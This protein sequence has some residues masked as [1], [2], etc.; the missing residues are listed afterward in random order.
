M[1]PDIDKFLIST[2]EFVLN[3]SESEGIFR[4]SG[5]VGRQRELKVAVEDGKPLDE[6][7]INDV[8]SLIKQFFREL[9]EPLIITLYHDAFIKCF[10]LPTEKDPKAALLR[11]CL[12]LPLENLGALRYT[13]HL[14]H[15][16]AQHS[17]KNRM[18]Y[19]NLA[20]VVA[21][22][23]MGGAGWKTGQKMGAAEEKILS[24][25]TSIIELLIRQWDQVG[26]VV[27]SLRQQL[28]M[29]SECFGTDDDMDVSDDNTLED[30]RDVL[31]KKRRRRSGSL[32]GIV[33]SIAQGIAKLRRSTDGKSINMSSNSTFRGE[34]SLSSDVS[35]LSQTQDISISDA[36]PYIMRKRRASGDAV[37]F[38][39]SKKQAILG[40][41]PTRSALASTPFTPSSTLKRDQNQRKIAPS[42]D[43]RLNATTPIMGTK[44]SRKKLNLFTSP[45]S[46]K[47]MKRQTSV[48]GRLE[49]PPT[50]P[51]KGKN[52][53]R[54]KSG[55]RDKHRQN[56]MSQSSENETEKKALNGC[57]SPK[58]A[59]SDP[60]LH[61]S[62]RTKE[63]VRATSSSSLQDSSESSLVVVD[64]DTDVVVDN[65]FYSEELSTE[66]V[67]TGSR[68][69]KHAESPAIRRQPKAVTNGFGKD[70]SRPRGKL[71]KS[72]ISKP[73]PLV[74]PA[75]AHAIDCSQERELRRSRR[76]EFE[77][78]Q[79]RLRGR[80]Q[81]MEKLEGRVRKA[82]SRGESPSK[83]DETS[84]LTNMAL[85]A[86][87]LDSSQASQLDTSLMEAVLPPPHGFGDQTML[88]EE[89]LSEQAHGDI[90]EGS[91][92]PDNTENGNL[93]VDSDC[94]SE[95]GFSTISGG[96]VMRR[97]ESGHYS[98]SGSSLVSSTSDHKSKRPISMPV[99]LTQQGLAD[100]SGALLDGNSRSE[101]S[102][103]KGHCVRSGERLPSEDQHVQ[104][105][106]Y[107]VLRAN[108][109]EGEYVVLRSKRETTRTA[110][111]QS[112]AESSKGMKLLQDNYHSSEED[113]SSSTH[114]KSDLNV[115]IGSHQDDLDNMPARTD[116][117][118]R[119]SFSAEDLQSQVRLTT[120]S[121]A[122]SLYVSPCR[123][124]NY[125]PHLE[126]S[127]ETHNILARAG[128]MEPSAP[129]DKSKD[130][131]VPVKSPTRSN[132]REEMKSILRSSFY[133]RHSLL[134]SSL[135][136]YKRNYSMDASLANTTSSSL[137]STSIS[138]EHDKLSISSQENLK[139]A[140]GDA[141]CLDRNINTV[142]SKPTPVVSELM[143]RVEQ[144][145]AGLEASNSQ[146]IPLMNGEFAEHNASSSQVKSHVGCPESL[147]KES[148]VPSLS[149]KT[150]D[151]ILR[152]TKGKQELGDTK[153]ANS[154]TN[155]FVTK[156]VVSCAE[157]F[158]LLKEQDQSLTLSG[159]L[160]KSLAS[161]VQIKR[162]EMLMPKHDSILDVRQA[163]IVAQSV[164]HFSKHHGKTE[165]AKSLD[166]PPQKRGNQALRIPTIFA[167]SEDEI[168]RYREM[169][170]FV[171]ERSG[172]DLE[173]GEP[174]EASD[175]DA[176][177]DSSECEGGNVTVLEVRSEDTKAK[178]GTSKLVENGDCGTA[179]KD[180]E[181][182]DS[183]V[184]KSPL[185]ECT[186]TAT[187]T[188]PASKPA[189]DLS[190]AVSSLLC[191]APIANC[192]QL[193]LCS[194][195]DDFLT[196]LASRPK[197]QT[198]P[199]TPGARTY[200]RNHLKRL[201]AGSASSRLQAFAS[202]SS[203]SSSSSLTDKSSVM[204]TDLPDD[205]GGD[206]DRQQV[207]FSTAPTGAGD[208]LHL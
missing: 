154:G 77:K 100:A 67:T 169:T 34:L 192:S 137:S 21:P 48:S 17:D 7:N 158:K 208:N 50:K 157:K 179:T 64:D 195:P 152:N 177:S 24:T 134:S 145:S 95:A 130:I 54:R 15:R 41:L 91:D 59:V 114:A 73:S 97:T 136:S 79:R 62:V 135:R 61:E 43:H 199:H 109:P 40:N 196:S 5:S 99:T 78:K 65:V 68:N 14:L 92:R 132:Y 1:T 108:D 98:V 36:T 128:Y 188:T 202:P 44:A 107:V 190:E 117:N 139:A 55:G 166:I 30:S 16:V 207:K 57:L 197:N 39:S 148:I 106:P 110:E 201:K 53:F 141:A 142:D 3:H 115:T 12:L 81:G 174:A 105:D 167:K 37:P 104:E 176:V 164:R 60:A 131:Y 23:L 156:P 206:G 66:G 204:G 155:L 175:E 129:T 147:S 172:C 2:S 163:G 25:Q 203:F 93:E 185:L 22:N 162:A 71:D 165:A 47:K 51:D 205:R 102:L 87:D 88:E 184:I 13:M 194:A 153:S 146:H 138:S 140:S 72:L 38:A 83:I 28:N 85:P 112:V 119:K 173:N 126:I 74:V 32:T 122:R 6:A 46:N 116:V 8:T 27:S 123:R 149:F 90:E 56:D 193:A 170:N 187:V 189:I 49:S 82:S 150:S 159:I 18:T 29:M 11:M 45:A 200:S 120:P 160:D 144:I 168:R 80:A 96:T 161:Q 89:L 125:K 133:D 127:R 121:R 186:N 171:R 70:S 52:I 143:Q 101:Q 181:S 26:M 182:Q 69:S 20:L 103:S 31:R 178:A 124:F 19:N 183:K 42:Q 151:E 180:T 10:Q 58:G 84:G 118:K 76:D 94:Q 4:K 111:R 113:S 63:L 9:P 75:M 191:D 35:T 86:V 198:R 33:S